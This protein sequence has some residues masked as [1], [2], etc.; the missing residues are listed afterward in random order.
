MNDNEFNKTCDFIVKLGTTALEFGISSFRLQS[1][2]NHATTALGLRGDFLVTPE[3]VTSVLWREGD[4]RQRVNI[5]PAHAGTNM[6]GIALVDELVEEVE[7]GQLSV[8]D[9][10][11]RLA[12]I[13]KSPPPFGP[14]MTAVSFGLIAAGFAVLLS[15]P[16]H[17][18]IIGTALSMVVYAVVFLLGRSP[19]LARMINP[20]AAFVA[21][22]L[23][24]A[25]AATIAPGS[26][27]MMVTLCAVIALIPNPGLVLGVG[28][29]AS[30]HVASGAE[31]LISAIV[32]L[33]ELAFGAFLGTAIA[34][35]LWTIP[36][37]SAVAS[38]GPI[39]AWPAVA[40]LGVGLAIL[41][42]V[43]PKEHFWVILGCLL[44]FAGVV[45]GGKL[46]GSGPGDLLGALILG[47]FA[48]AYALQ[49][50][51]AA[52]VIVCTGL[53]VLAPGY[54]SYLGLGTLQTTG[55][56]AG[57]LAEFKTFVTIFWIIGGLFIANT[58]IPPTSTLRSKLAR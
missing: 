30:N 20:L 57:L 24:Y 14:F 50:G 54:A 47:V 7:S 28:E 16:W 26:K 55:I 48:N 25:I 51:R 18:I 5:T 34:G 9:G 53:M 46:L 42:Q 15:L 49:R 45:I 8:E 17:D 3:K 39:W 33:I 31:R 37:A 23:A 10:T 27:H 4:E 56:E 43:R 32:T 19:R 1:H 40:V 41:F 13:E 22:I 44:A 11:A 29:L 12:E 6:A 52:S 38:L 2:L 21:A 58:I 35:A 36:E